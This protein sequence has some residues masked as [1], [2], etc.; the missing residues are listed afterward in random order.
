M[1]VMH[2]FWGFL[3]VHKKFWLLPLLIAMALFGVLT[4]L[5]QRPIPAELS[6]AGCVRSG[7]GQS[8]CELNRAWQADL[9][10]R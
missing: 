2:E 3:R 9:V 5:P 10:R 1:T 7:L 8:T 4:S 6:V